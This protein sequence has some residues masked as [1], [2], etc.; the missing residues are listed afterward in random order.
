MSKNLR[1]T[2]CPCGYQFNRGHIKPPLMGL[3]DVKGIKDPNFYGGT[4]KKFCKVEC[5]CG[6]E[7]LLYLMQ[8]NGEWAVKDI[9]PIEGT[10]KLKPDGD[11]ETHYKEEPINAE[12]AQSEVDLK[13]VVIDSIIADLPTM[14][15]MEMFALAKERGI[16]INT[17]GKNKEI[18]QQLTEGLR[19]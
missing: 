10:E 12:P 14:K 8:K 18:I 11:W 6:Q 9:E 17:K 1:S 13:A 4:V 5:D 16:K 2:M 3:F 19:A 15:R 7:Y